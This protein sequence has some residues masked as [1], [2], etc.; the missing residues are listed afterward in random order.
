MHAKLHY[1][2]DACETYYHYYNAYRHLQ[3]DCLVMCLKMTYALC[4]L[5][6]LSVDYKLHMPYS[7]F[8]TINMHTHGIHIHTYEDQRI[9]VGWVPNHRI[10]NPAGSFIGMEPVQHR[11]G[12]VQF[13]GHTAQ[14]F[15]F[16]L[17]QA[18]QRQQKPFK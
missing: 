15:L 11:A 14:M 2:Y 4:L 13:V 3:V 8:E 6:L 5:D 17:T 10:H 7:L 18:L 16:S 9:K 12:L 1:H